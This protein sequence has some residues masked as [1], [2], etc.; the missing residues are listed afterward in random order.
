[1]IGNQTS[2]IR[3]TQ[4]RVTSGTIRPINKKY[5]RAIAA[6]RNAHARIGWSGVISLCVG[7]LLTLGG[8]LWAL[9][10]GVSLPLVIMAG[11]C[12]LVANAGC[13]AAL[14]VFRQSG[15]KSVSI[16]GTLRPN[17]AA[18]TLV[19]TFRISDASRLWCDIEPGCPSSQESIAW[20]SAM[21]DAIKTGTLRISV[22][23][24]SNDEAV[25]REKANPTWHTMITR[26]ALKSWALSHG[27]CPAFLR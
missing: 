13:V 18:W 5:A 20:A 6:I 23:A 12:M 17:Y 15:Q 2:A 25:E 3:V 1:M 16:G 7:L 26:E 21:L 9:H 11:Y 8:I 10:D 14:L 4:S 22:K 19:S 27:H 24:G